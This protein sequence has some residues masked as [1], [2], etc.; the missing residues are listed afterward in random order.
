M[1]NWYVGLWVRECGAYWLKLEVF[2]CLRPPKAMGFQKSIIRHCHFAIPIHLY[3]CIKKVFKDGNRHNLTSEC[4]GNDTIDWFYRCKKAHAH[5]QRNKYK[6][7]L[8]CH[9][10]HFCHFEPKQPITFLRSPFSFN[11]FFIG[12]FVS[13]QSSNTTYIYIWPEIFKYIDTNI[14]LH[15]N[16]DAIHCGWPRQN[17]TIKYI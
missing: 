4:W 15:R 3:L 5:A 16:F 7:V 14:L 2:E 17:P 9:F 10:C 11:R 6:C 13:K 8:F 12:N 1:I